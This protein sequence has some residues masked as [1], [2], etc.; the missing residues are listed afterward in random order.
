MKWKDISLQGKFGIGFGSILVLL[1]LVGGWAIF[2]IDRIVD[3]SAQVI[4]NNKL[5]GLL[6]QYEVDYLNWNNKVNALL[7]DELVT[8]LDVETDSRKSAFGKWLYGEGRQKAEILVPGLAPLLKKIEAPHRKLHESAITIAEGFTQADTLLPGLLAVT[9]IDLLQWAHKIE[10]V[11]S[12][13]LPQ[14]YVE[15]DYRLSNLGKWLYSEEAGKMAEGDEE[16]ARLL[17]AIKEPHKRL[18]ESAIEIRKTYEQIHPGLITTLLTRLDDLHREVAAVSAGMIKKEKSLNI[19]KDPAKCSLGAWLQ[20]EETAADMRNFPKLKT[21]LNAVK[22]P[23]DRL[24]ASAIKIEGALRSGDTTKSE[25]I[26]VTE[27]LLAANEIEQNVRQVIKTEKGLVKGKEDAKNIYATKTQTVMAETLELLRNMQ[28]RADHLIRKANRTN[29][30]YAYSTLPNLQA[31]QELLADM[32]QEIKNN[33]MTDEQVLMFTV[34]TRTGILIIGAIASVSGVLLAAAIARGIVRPIRECMAFATAIAAGEL[35][36]TI[37]IHQKD[38]IGLLATAFRDMIA[39][40]QEVAAVAEKISNSNLQ[41][42][43]TPKSEQDVLNISLQRMVRTL[44]TVA[45]ENERAM[46]AVTHQNWLRTG[47]TELGKAMRG[48]QDIAALSKHIITCLANYVQAQV[49]LLYLTEEDHALHLTGSYAYTIRKGDYS[50]VR[51][52]ERL[53]GQAAFEQETILFA[54][55]PEDYMVIGSRL[56]ETAPRQ[57]LVVPFLYEG[58]VTGVVELGAVREFTAMQREFLTQVQESIAIAV[59]SAQT[60]VRMQNLLEASQQQAEELQAQQEGLRQANQNLAAQT[61]A[62]QASQEQ[63]RT[64]QEEL[65]Q[66]NEQLLEQTQALEKRET[67]LQDKNRELEDARRLIE[68]KAHDLE[69]SSRYKS[70]FLANMSHELRTPL[71][72]LLILSGVLSI[73]E[74]ENLSADQVE[75]A[76]TIHAAG[77]ELLTLINSV[78]DLA[79]V[80]SGKMTLNIEEMSVKGLSAYIT[81]NF[82]HVAEEKGLQLT[83]HLADSL[84]A[85]IRT[86]RQRVEQIVKNLL[87]NA[88]KFTAQGSVTLSMA[89]PAPGVEL[90]HSGLTPHTTV[91]I[92]VADTGAGIPEAKQRLI[93]E[94]FQQVD[95]STS[96]KYGGTG[97]GLSIS[98]ELAKLLGGE[99]QLQSEEDRGSTFTLYLPDILSAEARAEPGALS[100]NAGFQAALSAGKA[101]GVPRRPP[102]ILPPAPRLEEERTGVDGIWDD[103]HTAPAPAERSLLIIEDDPEYAKRLFDRVREQGFKGFLA[104]DGAVGLQLAYQYRPDAIILNLRLPD[105]EGRIVVQ[106]LKEQPD[107]R[108]IP[109]YFLSDRELSKE[110]VQHLQTDVESIIMKGENAPERVLDEVD[111]WL[112]RVASELPK[113]CQHLPP[114]S[115]DGDA[116]FHEKTL[117]LVDDD[118]RNLFAL[119]GVLQKK[120]MTVLT[121]VHGK[122]ALEQIATRPD[123]DLI[124]M[125]IMMPEMDGYETIRAIRTRPALGKLPIIALTAK[126]MKGDR[127]KCL[128]AGANDYLSKPIDLEKLFSLLRVWLY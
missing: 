82:Q 111:L 79:K 16:L 48:E 6:A 50:R 126:A 41:V 127:Q 62:L 54:D 70:E 23:H 10:D 114:A 26:Y 33:L 73:N 59:T 11:F 119:S 60:R 45:A 76:N 14:V 12:I 117:L 63:L 42:E 90:S 103:R 51:F 128:D 28:D 35:T 21:A 123:I 5:D 72:S 71:N 98:R 92:V 77:C 43:V 97:L 83:V 80:E 69:L 2:G 19:E 57:I 81:Q 61:A 88:L 40:I 109:V 67:A 52:G 121:A 99:I 15:T 30:I 47:Q 4:D 22:A 7:T 64:Q 68:D 38:E 104:G 86:D 84:P 94:A 49:G 8:R 96:R 20:S 53:V 107:T 102:P 56:G 44:R 112:H 36:I 85:A 31:L 29:I 24:H 124:L 18:Y 74:E 78:L 32:H 9:E 27:T 37:N 120:G 75:Y 58:A 113:H 1:I 106:R 108:D 34:D 101:A 46:A 3:N 110:E 55:V 87:S 95:G 89:R 100:G 39:Y 25:R 116:V 91:A 13:D 118:M 125:D 105:M 115:H 66:T 93:F 17:E 65:R 122:D